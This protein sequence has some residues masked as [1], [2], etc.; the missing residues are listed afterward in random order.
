[1]DV[2]PSGAVESIGTALGIPGGRVEGDLKHFKEFIE[3]RGSATGGWRGEVVQDDVTGSQ[4]SGS[5]AEAERELAGAGTMGATGS[6]GDLGSD[7]A[8]G[9]RPPAADSATGGLSGYQGDYASGTTGTADLST[10]TNP[11]DGDPAR[12]ETNP[13]F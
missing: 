5:T 11:Q 3:R 13:T 1:M 8:S 9:A 6:S 2:E 7:Y 12:R 10:G 4:G